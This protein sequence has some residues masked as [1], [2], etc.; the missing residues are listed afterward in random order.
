MH[1]FA[2]NVDPDL[3]F[4][5][6]IVPCGIA[7]K[8]V[9]S[10]RGRG[11]RRDHGRGRRRRRRPVRRL[12]AAGAPSTGPTSPGATPP[13]AP[14]SR[15]S[16]GA[17][18][19]A[20][21]C[22]SS[23][24]WPQ[25][26][27]DRRACR[28]RSASPTG[29]RPGSASATTCS[30]LKR[31]MRDLDLV[32][33]CEEAGCPNIFECWAD[34]T[35]TFMINGERCTRACGFC[36]VDTRHPEAARP[37][38]ARA[39]GR[40][41][42]PH[43]PRLRRRH[44]RR[45]RRPRRRR[46]R[47][48]RRHDRGHPAPAPGAR[49]E[50]LIPD[51]KGDADAAR[52]HLRRPPRR[53]QPQP[54]D[55]GP[56]AAGRA[57]VGRL[58]PHRCRC[59][60]GPRPPASSP[61]RASSSAWARPTTRSTSALADLRRRRRRHR[62]HRPVPA[63]HRRTTCRSTGGSSRRRS[64]RWRGGRA[65][66]S[67]SPT[68]R[69]VAAHPVAATTRPSRCTQPVSRCTQQASRCT[70]RSGRRSP[71]CWVG[72]GD[73]MSVFASRLD[74]TRSGWPSVGRRRAAAVGR[75]RPAVADRL[76]GDAARA[77]HHA[78]A[79]RATATPRSSC[80]CL[81][82]P[83][84]VERPEV[85]TLR[86]W[87]ETDDPIAVVAGLAGSAVR[88]SP[89][90]TARGP[91]SSST[92]RRAM[93]RRAWRRG[94][95]GG[96]AAAHGQGRRRDR[97]PAGRR[98]RPPTGWRPQLHG[99]EIP[100]VGRTEAEVSAD[101]GRR[102]LRRGPPQGQLRHRGRRGQRRQPHHEAGSRVIERRRGRAVRLRRH[103]ARARRRRVLLRHH[104][105]RVDR[106]RGAARRGRR[107]LRRAARRPA[108]GVRGR[109]P[110]APPCEDVDAAARTPIA[111]GR[112]GRAVHPPHRPRHRHRGARGPL[113]GGRQP[114]AAGRRATPSP[115]SPASTSPGRWG[116]RLEDIVVATDAGPE[117]LNRADHALVVV[118]A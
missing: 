111:G 16:A 35:A 102:L 65:R 18:A 52:D 6:H 54:R 30:G 9:T 73:D 32:T 113:R 39:G 97:R 68:S 78:R 17:P 50:V 5:G 28:S 53:A 89:S 94:E 12:V 92:C 91:A 55:R 51:C 13:T 107:G 57:A 41:G 42:R 20:S 83:R 67:A 66:R 77:A 36:L 108:G 24:G 34:G 88:S 109:P 61:S 104:P 93:P 58:R 14:T 59:W 38:R 31:T 116:F 118:D 4:F 79:C 2:L 10:L 40:G 46:R 11:R 26:G 71:S 100:L 7:D 106:R 82:A 43:G 25:A 87:E 62:H 60:P 69:P 8:A 64:T 99:G 84:V 48:L 90:A 85:F 105:V 76:R 22:A 23:A 56:A 95:R 117:E 19:P 44:R 45:P 103:D 74:R 70:Q 3:A 75:A 1:G 63:P 86:T 115:S 80:R 101:I 37:R 29:S 47:R 15:R 33:V 96:R 110:S 81:E 49:V 21:R 98:R 114:H 72:G 27:V 112:V